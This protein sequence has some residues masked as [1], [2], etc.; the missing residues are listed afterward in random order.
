[1]RVIRS[2]RT[3]MKVKIRWVVMSRSEKYECKRSVWAAYLSALLKGRVLKVYDRLPVD[4]SAY[5]EK[6]KD[7]L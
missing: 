5:Y 1:M 4:V 3:L 6:L 7:A 2:Y